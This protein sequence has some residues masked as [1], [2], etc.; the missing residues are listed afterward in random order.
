MKDARLLGMVADLVGSKT[1]HG[2]ISK[3]KER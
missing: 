1:D 2:N 3:I